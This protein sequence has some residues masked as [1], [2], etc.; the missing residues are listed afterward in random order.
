MAYRQVPPVMEDT[1]QKPKRIFFPSVEDKKEATADDD[2]PHHHD[3]SMS[4]DTPNTSIDAGAEKSAPSVHQNLSPVRENVKIFSGES[5]SMDM[6]ISRMTRLGLKTPINQLKSRRSSLMPMNRSFMGNV[7]DQ[8]VQESSQGTSK[9]TLFDSSITEEK[10]SSQPLNIDDD[11]LSV[12]LERTH[13]HRKRL[14]ERPFISE[15]FLSTDL[16]PWDNSA[17]PENIN[18]NKP[19]DDNVIVSGSTSDVQQNLL[20]DSGID[21]AMKVDD[22]DGDGRGLEKVESPL[23]QS[24]TSTPL[25]CLQLAGTQDNN[26]ILNESLVFVSQILFYLAQVSKKCSMKSKIYSKCEDLSAEVDNDELADDDDGKVILQK[27]IDEAVGD[28]LEPRQQE[29]VR[30]SFLKSFNEEC[31]KLIDDPEE[32]DKNKSFKADKNEYHDFQAIR[33]I[34]SEPDCSSLGSDVEK[35]KA[36]TIVETRDEEES[37]DQGPGQDESATAE[38]FSKITDHGFTPEDQASLS[39][40]ISY[41]SPMSYIQTPADTQDHQSMSSM[42]SSYSSDSIAAELNPGASGAS[43]LSLNYDSPRALKRSSSTDT[44]DHQSLSSLHSSNSSESMA[45]DFVPENQEP[46]SLLVNIGS[47]KRSRKMRTNFPKNLSSS[48]SAQ[49]QLYDSNLSKSASNLQSVSTHANQGSSVDQDLSEAASS[50]SDSD[51]SK[52]SNLS[53]TRFDEHY[54]KFS[55]ASTFEFGRHSP[56]RSHHSGS[57]FRRFSPNRRYS[58]V[59]NADPGAASFEQDSGPSGLMILEEEDNPSPQVMPER[60]SRPGNF[61]HHYCSPGMFLRAMDSDDDDEKDTSSMIVEASTSEPASIADLADA[62]LDQSSSSKE[63]SDLNASSFGVQVSKSQTPYD[64]LEIE[65]SLAKINSLMLGLK[66]VYKTTTEDESKNTSKLC[67]IEVTEV[68]DQSSIDSPEMESMEVTGVEDQSQ[69]HHE[70]ESMEVTGTEEESKNT[71]EL[72]NIETIELNDSVELL[73]E[74]AALETEAAVQNLDISNRTIDLDSTVEIKDDSFVSPIETSFG[75]DRDE[76]SGSIIDSSVVDSANTTTF[77]DA[78]ETLDHSELE[79]SKPSTSSADV[80]SPKTPTPRSRRKAV[81]LFKKLMQKTPHAGS[82]PI[83]SS[84]AVEDSD[85]SISIKFNQSEKQPAPVFK[86]A[87]GVPFPPSHKLTVAEVFDART[88]RPRPDVL[89]HHFI[90]EG[91]IDEAAAL[92]IVN[93]GA[94]LLRSEKTM[95]DIEAPVTVCGD[96]HG[97]F[98]DLMKLFEVGG[99]PSTTKYLFLGDYV[100]R[101]YFSIEC[102]LYLWALKLCHPTT[103]FLLRGNHECRHLTEYFTFKQ[104][105]KIKYSEKVYDA[106]MDAFD[107]LPLAA[108]MNQQFLCVHGGLSP[109]IHHLEDIRKLDRF[110]EPPAYGPMCDLL[111]SDPLEDFGNEKNAE[112]FSHNSVRGC[113]YFYSYAACCDFLQNNSLL[114]IIRAHEAQDAGYRMYRKSQ[115]TGFPSLITIFSAPNYLDVYN[116]KA[117]VLKYENNV[118][119]IRQFNCSPHPYW[120]PNF[121]DVFTWSLPFVGEKVTEMLVN[122]LNICSDDELMSDGDDALEEVAAKVVVQKKNAAN[123]RKEVIRNKIRA[124]GKMARVFSVLREESESVLQLKGLTPTGALPLGALSGGKTS[125][126]NALQGFSPNHKITSFAEAKGLDAIN[127]RMPPRKDAPPTPVNEEKPVI[128]PAAAATGEKRDQ[129]TPQPHS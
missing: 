1:P 18:D 99:P 95:I 118:M 114:S 33:K 89:K 36:A 86:R 112:H 105:C 76:H 90:L 126:K 3:G 83:A 85:N 48:L 39:S 104:E 45:A 100:D 6:L 37:S 16:I 88:G 26:S 21:A 108:L 98:Y 87:E 41:Q 29:V 58:N 127:E 40:I 38:H 13:A 59:F 117:A 128:K 62:S 93:D 30:K 101:G 123:L 46:S 77:F 53:T 69:S 47:P 66:N 11:Y 31:V 43:S 97:Q 10:S 125:L 70:L 44:K 20:K 73:V 81:S 82:K 71:S 119:N 74:S 57:S 28:L 27:A 78:L 24:A 113:S 111:W 42:Q 80:K 25:Q 116:N 54:P 32:F 61:G 106:C 68:E 22:A 110:K 72:K 65:E 67:T 14:S 75:P 115:T 4:T 23:K 7:E 34:K 109:E 79:E 17:S 63:S 91:R 120:L 60:P 94:S 96:I 35:I 64:P 9:K 19:R 84:T 107:C 50:L 55:E 129:C 51:R 124:I 103:L 5:P 12:A 56:T 102:V 15:S 92:R 121:M 49:S 122:V 52:H 2:N 8:D